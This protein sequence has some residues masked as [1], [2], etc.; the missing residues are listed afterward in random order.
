MATRAQTHG[1]SKAEPAWA[2]EYEAMLAAYKQA[3][4]D[5]AAL[6]TPRAA[7]LVVSANRV[8]A[9]NEVPGVH[10][11]A[12]EQPHGIRARIVVEPDLRLGRPVHLCFGMLPAEGRQEIVADYEIGP[13]AQVEFIAHCTFPNARRLQHVMDARIHVAAGATMTYS[14]SHFHGPYGGIEVRP[15]AHVTVEDGGRFITSFSLINGRVGRLDFDYDVV[16]GAGGVAELTTKAYGLADDH[17]KVNETLHLNGAA[18]RGLT[19]TRIAVRD[20]A[21]SEVFT[22]AEGNAPLARGHMDCTEVVRDQATAR[23]MPLVV[24]RDDRAQVT[25]EASI[26]TVNHKELETL[27]ARGLDEETAVDVIIRGMLQS[28]KED[29]P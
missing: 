17:V 26:G 8:L 7:T 12:E 6:K 25:H 14:E 9:A 11:E 15:K 10:F 27:M 28:P 13:R 22:T 29:I 20:R 16:V 2:R 5:P 23:N 19:K 18:A 24:V 4:G 1:P 3:G 21:V